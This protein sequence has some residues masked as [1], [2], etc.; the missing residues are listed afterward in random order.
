MTK[1][2]AKKRIEKLRKLIERYSY[3]YHVLDRPSVPDAVWDSLK[4]ELTQLEE[5][6]PEFITSDS[7]TQRV[8][9]KPLKS[10]TKVRHVTPILSLQDVFS[11]DEV[12]AWEARV[13][14]LAG[15]ASAISYYAEVKMDGL[16]IS[17]VYENGALVRAATRG[18]GA[19]GEDVTHNIRTIP[20]IPLKLRH[21]ALPL[22]QRIEVRGEVFMSKA[23]FT[24]L[25]ALQKKRREPV[26]ANPRNAAAGSVRQ[27]DPKTTASRK[28]DFFAYDVLA[29]TSFATHQEAHECARDIGFKVNAEN[30]HCKSLPDVLAYFRHIER[31]RVKLPYQ[32]DGIVVNVDETPVFKKLGVVGKAP[33]AAVAFKFSP[34]ETTTVLRAIRLQVGRTGVITP[35]ADMNPV[36]LAGT[37]V[38]R[39]TLHNFDEIER[40]GVRIGDTIVVRK[41][42]DIIPDVVKVLPQLRTGSEKKFHPP[43]QCP[44]CDAKVTRRTDEVALYCSNNQCPAR[45]HEALDHFVSRKAFDIVGLGTKVVDALVSEGLVREPADFFRLKEADV[46]KLPLFAEKRAENLIRA[47]RERKTIP[48]ARFIF[49]L[50]IRHVGEETAVDLNRHFGSLPNVLRAS[51]EDFD[52]VPGIG[53]V[54]SGSVAAYFA[55]PKQREA[56]KHLLA[57]GIRVLHSERPVNRS[58]AGQT[59]VVTGTLATMTREDAHARI[60]EHGGDVA[61]SVSKKTSFV[62]VGDDPGSKAEKAEKLGVRR[63][64][65]KEF[66]EMLKGA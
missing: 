47:I 15:S 63:V 27:L 20:T 1:G 36:Q 33:R 35:V 14:K 21:G 28:L 60:R 8:A 54:V 59:V 49:A 17:I 31:L 38:A 12:G 16:A 40:L 50:G 19:V 39:A 22:R 24:A 64:T 41:A 42:G 34:E 51:K 44:V 23:A 62:V 9:G 10:F 6:F 3:E 52:H 25:N 37:T 66:L 61:S 26:F 18:D 58:L 4:R 13:R 11:E 65:E 32:I 45:R 56:V 5:R 2:E 53:T 46:E 57:V 55:D 29:E 48:L 7:P 30:R 43:K